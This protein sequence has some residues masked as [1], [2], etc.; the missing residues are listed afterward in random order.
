MTCPR[1]RRN[2]LTEIFASGYAPGSP[3]GSIRS[4]YWWPFRFGGRI[5]RISPDTHT[6]AGKVRF[7][8]AP[9]AAPSS[10]TVQVAAGW[11]STG[12]SSAAIASHRVMVDPGY[13]RAVPTG[14]GAD[15]VFHDPTRS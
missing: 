12:S 8:P 7:N 11:S 10:A 15:P 3:P 1:A 6:S 9:M 13:P 2:R 5:D 14:V 4:K